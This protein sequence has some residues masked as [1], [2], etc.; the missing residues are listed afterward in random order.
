MD[1]ACR[2]ATAENAALVDVLLSMP[3]V[4]E[5]MSDDELVALL[6]PVTYLDPASD[7][8]DRALADIESQA[9]ARADAG[10]RGPGRPF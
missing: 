9:A 4:S 8:V 1:E 7:I 5:A 3:E 10:P 6:K 2:R